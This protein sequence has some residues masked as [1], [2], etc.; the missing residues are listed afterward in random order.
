MVSEADEPVRGWELETEKKS[1]PICGGTIGK[2]EKRE[3]EKWMIKQVLV[4]FKLIRQITQVYQKVM[5]MV[6]VMV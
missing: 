2:E 6:V 3:K 4:I 1:L 5:V